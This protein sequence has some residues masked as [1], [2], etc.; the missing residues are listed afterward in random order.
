MVVNGDLNGP[1]SYINDRRLRASNRANFT[2]DV[3]DVKVGHGPVANP[4]PG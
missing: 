4:F 3:N 2:I 1:R